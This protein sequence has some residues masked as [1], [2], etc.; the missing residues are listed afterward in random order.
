MT[1][2]KQTSVPVDEADIKKLCRMHTKEGLAIRLL[3]A[4]TKLIAM[5][6]MR[7]GDAIDAKTQRAD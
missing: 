6:I 2:K 5:D 4:E 7:F 3:E 1:D